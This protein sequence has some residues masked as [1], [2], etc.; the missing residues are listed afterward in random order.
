M[1]VGRSW[2]GADLNLRLQFENQ[3][4]YLHKTYCRPDRL[5]WLISFNPKRRSEK[6]EATTGNKANT[7]RPATEFVQRCA[8]TEIRATMKGTVSIRRSSLKH[9]KR[10]SSRQLSHVPTNNVVLDLCRTT[11]VLKLALKRDILGL[12]YAGLPVWMATSPASDTMAHTWKGHGQ[13][14]SLSVND[15]WSS[16]SN[17]IQTPAELERA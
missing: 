12:L 4:H 17:N 15:G 8:R 5:W 2:N 9:W 14:G 11:M 6:E 3:A 13:G 16:L 1:R 10:K 7:K